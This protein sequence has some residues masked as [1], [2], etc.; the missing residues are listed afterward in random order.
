MLSEEQIDKLI[1]SCL[2]NKKQALKR[3]LKNGK[4]ILELMKLDIEFETLIKIR[5]GNDKGKR[6]G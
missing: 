5:Y 2:F 4:G 1:K 6:T 3:Y